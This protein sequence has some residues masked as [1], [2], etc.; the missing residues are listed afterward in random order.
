VGRAILAAARSAIPT[1]QPAD[2]LGDAARKITA[3]VAGARAA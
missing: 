3:A 2:D 1:M